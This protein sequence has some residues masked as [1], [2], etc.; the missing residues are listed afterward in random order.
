MIRK[1]DT[2]VVLTGREKNKTG[3]ILKVI[4]KKKVLIEKL[5]MVKKHNKPTQTNPTGGV[6]EKESA[7]D[8][9]NVQLFCYT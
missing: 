5:N 9:S 6:T 1:G 8:I 7:M 3:K 2:V 4:D